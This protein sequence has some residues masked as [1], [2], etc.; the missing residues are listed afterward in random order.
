MYGTCTMGKKRLIITIFLTLILV[1]TL[2]PLCS[3]HLL[4]GAYESRYINENMRVDIH[5]RGGKDNS[6]E[7]ISQHN[8]L[9]PDWCKGNNGRCA[10]IQD[11][12]KSKWKEYKISIKAIKAG[13]I[14]IDLRGPDRRI[15]NQRYPVV[16]DYRHLQVNGKLLFH[17]LQQVWYD[18]PFS[19]KLKVKDGEVVNISFWAR[20]H[21]F[22]ISDLINI[23]QMN[24]LLLFILT[25]LSFLFS[26]K[27]INYL[28]KF[29]TLELCS[30]IDIVFLTF[31]AVGLYLP[32]SNISD[33]EKSPQENRMLA[34]KPIFLNKRGINLKYG[35]Q[36]ETWFNDRFFG[37]KYLTRLFDMLN[38]VTHSQIGNA[39][40]LIGL[41][42][43]LFYKGENGLENYANVTKFSQEDMANGLEYLKD[44]SQWCQKNNKKFYFII[45]PDKNKIYGEYFRQ[46]KK[47]NPDSAGTG[48]QFVN[49]IKKNSDIEP[50]YL[51][52]TL[53]KHKDKG[54]LFYKSDAHWSKLGAYYGY[55]T[56]MENISKDFSLSPIEEFTWHAEKLTTGDLA[57][58]CRTYKGDDALYSVPKF[59]NNITCTS[60]IRYN[61]IDGFLE[62]KNPN[63]NYNVYT[64][65]DSFS[66]NLIDYYAQ[67]FS[68]VQF[69]WKKDITKRDLDNIKKNFDIVIFETVERLIPQIFQFT[70]PK[71]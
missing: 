31:L 49:Y 69:H 3:N 47:V 24:S 32:M 36:F 41:D 55:Q 48:W 39:K 26:Y 2:L 7:L 52:D 11:Q 10:V 18:K 20:K 46:V 54:L 37:R 30:R 6:I 64:L 35:E 21:H 5:N 42:N 53:I 8:S 57:L 38:Y 27:F 59:E 50:I 63:R 17:K 13:E 51:Y 68:L 23:Y 25:C 22:K 60:E 44:F 19:Y 28:V 34:M 58:I 67:T 12:I 62:C 66:T 65:R 16:V 29:E 61:R 1:L 43:W 14:K 9:M 15:E 40:I 45:A 70:F 4:R 33:L 56:I 71:D